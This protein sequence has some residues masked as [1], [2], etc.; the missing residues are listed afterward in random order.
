MADRFY[1]K[2]SLPHQSSQNREPEEEKKL[3]LIE[4]NSGNEPG[5]AREMQYQQSPLGTL[6]QAEELELV[7]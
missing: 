4:S 5:A 1:G 3:E 2:C 6:H 7:A